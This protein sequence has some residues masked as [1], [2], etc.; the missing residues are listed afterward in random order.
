MVGKL[1]FF[2]CRNIGPRRGRRNRGFVFSVVLRMGVGGTYRDSGIRSAI[3]CTGIIGAIHHIFYTRGCS[4]LRG[5]TR[6]IT[7][8]VLRRCPTIF[9][10]RVALGGPRTPIGTS[11]SCV[12]MGVIHDESWAGG[13]I[14]GAVGKILV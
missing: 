5:Y 14:L 3:S 12:T 7:S 1:G 4:L 2:T 9:A 11:F 8:T 6:I 10:T 13:R